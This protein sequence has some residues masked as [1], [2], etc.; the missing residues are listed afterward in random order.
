MRIFR[1]FCK[2]FQFFTGLGHFGEEESRQAG[3]NV[4]SYSDPGFLAY[5]K[6]MY[7]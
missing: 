4:F 1:S 5:N 3:N 7:A 2:N 6:G